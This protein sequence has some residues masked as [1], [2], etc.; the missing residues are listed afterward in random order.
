MNNFFEYFNRQTDSLIV[1]N[2]SSV[3]ADE[4]LMA[5]GS[6]YGYDNVAGTDTF[7]EISIPVLRENVVSKASHSFNRIRQLVVSLASLHEV[8]LTTNLE[9]LLSTFYKTKRILLLESVSYFASIFK[10]Y[11][12]KHGIELYTSEF[13]GE[14][15]KPGEVIN[16]T[17]HVDIQDTHFQDNFFDLILHTEVFEHVPNAI[18]GEKEIVRILKRNGAAIFTVPFEHDRTTD[19]VFAEVKN[20][21]IKYF[22]EPI[23]HDDPMSNDGKCLVF[24]TFSLPDMSRRFR[25]IGCS[26]YCEYFHSEYLGILGNNAFTFVT[27]KNNA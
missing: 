6:F 9:T 23:Y 2:N 15:K 11:C 16:G 19:N 8:D 18:K 3:K 7:F 1:L 4:K 10:F 12:K 14:D 24:R 20:N 26:F 13:M 21:S 22:Q 5:R 17:L 25:N 27:R